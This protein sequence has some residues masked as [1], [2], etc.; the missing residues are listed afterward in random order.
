MLSLVFLGS[1]GGLK[2]A[3][4]C[5]WRG[6]LKASKSLR[7]SWCELVHWRR[8]LRWS[9]KMPFEFYK[10]FSEVSFVVFCVSL[11]FCGRFWKMVLGRI[12]LREGQQGLTSTVEFV[13]HAK[14]DP[15]FFLLTTSLPPWL[16]SRII[17]LIHSEKFGIHESKK[18]CS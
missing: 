15:R 11:C 3:Q 2:E 9:F 8:A 12:T 5:S 18:V 17:R 13:R 10:C 1:G 7:V 4:K 16:T 14:R 6:D